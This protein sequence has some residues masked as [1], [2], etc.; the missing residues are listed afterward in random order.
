MENTSVDKLRALS[1][2]AGPI[3]INATA[4]VR[5]HSQNIAYGSSFVLL[6]R[7]TGTGPD[8]DLYL[9]QGPGLPTT[10][11]SAGDSADGWHQVGAKLADVTDTNWHAVV[12]APEALP[13]LRI[14]VDG[15][16]TNPAN[17]TIELRL[18]KQELLD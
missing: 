2:L 1:G 12:L 3:A 13:Y 4:D 15:Q 14:L 9:E 18:S 17:S 8:M 10:E 11:G 16:G 6:Y 5:T 7:A